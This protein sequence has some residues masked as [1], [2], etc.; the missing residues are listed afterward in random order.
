MTTKKQNPGWQAGASRVA[1]A[2]IHH[3]S[4]QPSSTAPDQRVQILIARYRLSHWTAR[5]VARLCFGEGR[6]D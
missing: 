2:A 3:S 5:E 4:S 6:D 1:R